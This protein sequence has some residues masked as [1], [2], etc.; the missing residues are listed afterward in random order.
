MTTWRKFS[1][2]TRTRTFPSFHLL[3]L[4]SS[5]NVNGGER[6]SSASSPLLAA[7]LYFPQ[8]LKPP[9]VAIP[10]A[11]IFLL[12]FSSPLFI[13]LYSSFGEGNSPES[14]EIHLQ[15]PRRRGGRGKIWADGE[16]EE[17]EEKTAALGRI[18]G[19]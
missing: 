17:R 9:C 14:P 8:L 18:I 6:S 5:S 13:I 19:G 12:P 4:A 1:G 15:N 10:K 16:G 3:S 11:C 2:Q 7:T